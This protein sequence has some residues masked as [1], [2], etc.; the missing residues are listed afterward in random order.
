MSERGRGSRGHLPGGLDIW[1]SVLVF[2]TFSKLLFA[3]LLGHLYHEDLVFT[4]VGG[5]PGE[6]L[7]AGA[8]YAHQ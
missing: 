6:A 5:H 2:L 3:V 7:P 1:E 8:A 4:D